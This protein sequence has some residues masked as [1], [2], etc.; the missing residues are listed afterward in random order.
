[1]TSLPLHTYYTNHMCTIRNTIHK[2]TTLAYLMVLLLILQTIK[3]NEHMI[4]HIVKLFHLY[5]ELYH[6]MGDRDT[7]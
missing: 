7:V 3:D 5:C 2:H 6:V 1:M 4:T